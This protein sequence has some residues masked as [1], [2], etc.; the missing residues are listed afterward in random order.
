MPQQNTV[1][2]LAVN[3]SPWTSLALVFFLVALGA[4]VGQ[5]VTSMLY[6]SSARGVE[7]IM[8]TALSKQP[9]LVLQATTA[10]SAF[11]VAPLLYLRIF[12]KQGIR[13]LFRWRQPYTA[14]ML[15]TLG[16][17]LAFMVVDTWFI[18]WNMALTLPTW[19]RKF[20]VWA[21]EKEAALQRIT[22]LL[23]TFRSLPELGVGILVI[24]VIPAVGEELLFRG[25]V[26]NIF[27]QLTTNVHLA[28]GISAFV[29]SAIHLQFYG[30]VPRFLLGML[31]GYIYWWTKD[32]FFPIAAHLF[33]NTFTL[34]ML[35]LHQQDIIVQDISTLQ[36]P[37]GPV[38]IFFVT[39]VI[40]LASLLQQQGKRANAC[41]IMH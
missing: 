32:L 40:A 26:Q 35:F 23:T 30:F 16:L 29:F 27:H 17:V 34:L 10:T 19:L 15:V 1:P 2:P 28:I 12:T 14:P 31:F 18:Q 13:E 37:P 21:Q 39:V 33:N 3:R 38:L 25:L 20:E 22:V 41:N 9:L 4:F 8:C 5:L 11:I 24:G 36:A 6:L 7:E